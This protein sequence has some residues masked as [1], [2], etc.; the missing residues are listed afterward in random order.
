MEKILNGLPA[1]FLCLET[2]AFRLADVWKNFIHRPIDF[3]GIG[4]TGHAGT[5]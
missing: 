3:A 5:G 2:V 4:K 1:A